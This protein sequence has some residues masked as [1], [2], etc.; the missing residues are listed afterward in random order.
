[1][2]R[3]LGIVVLISLCMMMTATAE[4]APAMY[5]VPV[6][7]IGTCGE[8]TMIDL[9]V[10]T[11]VEVTG[12]QAQLDFDE[13]CVNIT[14]VDFTGS[15]WQPLLPPGWSHYGNYVRLGSL[16][17]SP[18]S[19]GVHKVA[20]I[21]IN[22]TGC[23]CTTGIAI[24]DFMP[25]DLVT[26]DTEFICEAAVADGSSVSYTVT[27]YAG[28]STELTI[29]SADF[30]NMMR[31]D[32][33]EIIDS[34]TLTN[35]GDMDAIVDAAFTTSVSGMYGMVSGINTVPGNNFLLGE[36]TEEKVLT[37]D[38]TN[39]DIGIVPANGAVDYDA[40]LTIPID[41]VAGAY[42]GDVEVTYV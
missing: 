27:V 37:A 26:H 23:D 20:T 15:P 12:V 35:G 22:C 2:R 28:Q 34:L 18:V 33:S 6:D 9:M 31:G 11:S 3:I 41:A 30:G 14:N 29:N 39:V 13:T 21:T 4:D 16:D 36:D 7:G 17:L 5:F 40:I 42:S 10:N 38:G 25:A 32:T 24:S 1:M 19:H 8:E